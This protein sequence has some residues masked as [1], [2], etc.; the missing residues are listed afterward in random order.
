MNAS[1]DSIKDELSGIWI[2]KFETSSSNPSAING[3]ENVTDLDVIIRSNITSWRY[4]RMLC[5]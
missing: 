3:G 1:F 5:R 4:S 2:G